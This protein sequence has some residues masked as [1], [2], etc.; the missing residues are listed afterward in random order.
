MFA[1]SLF[2][3]YDYLNEEKKT[4][5][6]AF[7]TAYNKTESKYLLHLVAALETVLSNSSNVN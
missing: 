3:K 4:L 1:A 7:R 5:N 2:T 6:L